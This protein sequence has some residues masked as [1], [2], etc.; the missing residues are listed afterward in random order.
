MY[1]IVSIHTCHSS[2]VPCC[3]VLWLLSCIQWSFEFRL[4]YTKLLKFPFNT[5]LSSTFTTKPHKTMR[6][7]D[8]GEG[9]RSQERSKG[10]VPKWTMVGKG[11][12]AN[13]A[14]PFS[15]TNS[16]GNFFRENGFYVVSVDIDLKHSPTFAPTFWSGIIKNFRHPHLK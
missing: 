12:K 11:K 6:K 1:C 7:V 9:K 14:W 10:S 3:Y 2:L 5:P 13:D 16:V 8:K 15:G 4:L